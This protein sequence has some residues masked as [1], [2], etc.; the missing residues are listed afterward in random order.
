MATWKKVIVSGSNASL[1]DVSASGGF[2]GDGSAITNL[3]TLGNALTVD[4]STIRVNS[5]TT[6]DGGAARTI[7]VKPGGIVEA[8]MAAN[9]ILS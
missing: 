7:S 1:A 3:G 6:Y 8:S 2:I 9:S 5:G 4:N